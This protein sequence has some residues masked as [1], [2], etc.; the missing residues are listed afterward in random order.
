MLWGKQVNVETER[1][2]ILGHFS[3]HTETF[4]TQVSFPK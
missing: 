3:W 1:N 2:I 4:A